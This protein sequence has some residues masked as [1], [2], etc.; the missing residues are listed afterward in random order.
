MNEKILKR[1]DQV[2]EFIKKHGAFVNIALC[3]AF[4]LMSII[5]P[6]LAA[7]DNY[8]NTVKGVVGNMADIIGF[9]FQAVGV[10]LAV[11]SVGQLIL[12]FKNEDADSKSRASTQLVVAIALIAVPQMLKSINAF[13]GWLNKT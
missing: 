7:G 4:G 3:L 5:D 8:Q 2:M 11:Y 1:L 10:I 13:N 6:A 9:I 12:A